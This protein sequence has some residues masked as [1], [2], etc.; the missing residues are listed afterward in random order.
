MIRHGDLD[1]FIEVYLMQDDY[2]PNL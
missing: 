1:P 2:D